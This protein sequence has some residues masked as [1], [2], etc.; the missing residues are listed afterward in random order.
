MAARL[1][2]GACA[3]GGQGG[4]AGHVASAVGADVLIEQLG[5]WDKA[6]QIDFDALPERFVLKCT[7]NPAA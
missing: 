7:H 2:R 3:T 5:I 6:D 4:C 1:G